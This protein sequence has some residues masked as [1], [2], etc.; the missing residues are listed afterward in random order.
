EDTSVNIHETPQV[1]MTR[2]G[3]FLQFAHDG[4][5]YKISFVSDTEA[6][7]SVTPDSNIAA[8][9]FVIRFSAN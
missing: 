7:L 1:T 5:V 3:N 6:F 9:E 4:D 2:S 8:G